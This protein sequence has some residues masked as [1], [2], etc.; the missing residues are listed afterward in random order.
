VFSLP[1]G[2]RVSGGLLYFEINLC[3]STRVKRSIITRT[4][5]NSLR[6]R[7]QHRLDLTHFAH[8]NPTALRFELLNSQAT[9]RRLYQ[10]SSLQHDIV[11]EMESSQNRYVQIRTL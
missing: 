10:F 5:L 4:Y 11:R 7:L 8:R 3:L 1:L 2:V 6:D 9:L